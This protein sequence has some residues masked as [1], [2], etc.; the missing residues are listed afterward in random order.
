MEAMQQAY[1]L[2]SKSA[3]NNANKGKKLYDRKVHSSVLHPGDRVLVQNLTP[4]GGTGKLRSHWEQDVHVVVRRK[5]PESPI[6]DVKPENGKERD[7]TLHRNLFLQ[8][9]HLP[10][11]KVPGRASSMEKPTRE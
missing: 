4:R 7:R 5:D 2:A 3:L 9:D 1:K 11:D 8:C 6:Y 10:Y